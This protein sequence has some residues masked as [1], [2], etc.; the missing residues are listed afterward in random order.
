MKTLSM[1]SMHSMFVR[2][3][4]RLLSAQS[5]AILDLDVYDFQ[6]IASRFK[7]KYIGKPSVVH[8]LDVNLHSLDMVF[9]ES[10]QSITLSRLLADSFDDLFTPKSLSLEACRSTPVWWQADPCHEPFWLPTI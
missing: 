9:S 5:P 10:E 6:H 1:A 4:C 8:V 7:L 2:R 3:R